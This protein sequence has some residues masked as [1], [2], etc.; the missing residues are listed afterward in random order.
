MLFK[1]NLFFFS[2]TALD[3]ELYAITNIVFVW[4]L[5]DV[6]FITHFFKFAVPTTAPVPTTGED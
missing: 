4:K 1:V 2:V 5:A 6:I 3:W